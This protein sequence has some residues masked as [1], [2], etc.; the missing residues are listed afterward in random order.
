MSRPGEID[1]EDTMRIESITDSVF[2]GGIVEEVDYGPFKAV[3]PAVSGSAYITG[4]H[5]FV[6]DPND[7]ISEG[8][9]LR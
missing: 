5:T 2:T 7:P 9:I 3:I 4:L 6:L 1:F 8:F